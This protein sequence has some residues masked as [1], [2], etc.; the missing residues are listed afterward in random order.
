MNLVIFLFIEIEN[1]MWKDVQNLRFS[2]KPEQK[3]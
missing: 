2:L 3:T 1:L